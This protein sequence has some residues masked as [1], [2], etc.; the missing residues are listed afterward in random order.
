MIYICY[1][2]VMYYF[3]CLYTQIVKNNVFDSSIFN[4]SSFSNGKKNLIGA[5][6]RSKF[7][8]V[9]KSAGKKN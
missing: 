5:L 1:F 6:G 2:F 7:P 3:S 9:F 4:F 8:V